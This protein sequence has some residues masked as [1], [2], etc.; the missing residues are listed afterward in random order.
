MENTKAQLVITPKRK[1]TTDFHK[2]I[3]NDSAWKFSANEPTL[4]KLKE[5]VNVNVR[6]VFE[7]EFN[8]AYFN[9]FFN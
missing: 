9:K 5:E 7:K 8:P 6:I 4:D 1:Y 3:T 2:T